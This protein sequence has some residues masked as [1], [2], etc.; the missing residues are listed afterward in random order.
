M[1][2]GGVKHLRKRMA[3]GKA[4]GMA[5]IILIHGAWH[6]GWCWT[7]TA[8]ALRDMGHRVACPELPDAPDTTLEDCVAALPAMVRPLVVGHSMGGMVAEA[9]TAP[10]SALLH[11][12]SYLPLAGDSLATLDRLL[13]AQPRR[14]PRDDLGR[15]ILPPDDARQ[16]IYHDYPHAPIHALRPQPAGPMR[17]RLAQR[18][19]ITRHYVICENDRA[20]P[21]ALQRAMIDRAGV[22]HIHHRPWGHS[23]FLSDPTGLA[24]LIDAAT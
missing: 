18:R 9:M 19:R 24:R 8:D 7:A 6:G 2:R 3:A 14:W 13:P 22:D 15:L 5:D 12:C 10:A 20:I 21:P 17:D 11:L 23:P 16:M 4:C 1:A